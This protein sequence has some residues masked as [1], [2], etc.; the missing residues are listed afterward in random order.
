MT[1]ELLGVLAD[2]LIEQE[3][4]VD[5]KADMTKY[6]AI[7]Y[8]ASQNDFLYDHSEVGAVT[9][10][11]AHA[12]VPDLTAPASSCPSAACW[13]SPLTQAVLDPCGKHCKPVL[14]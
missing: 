3:L 5:D 9:C 7:T 1:Q 13:L 6:Q 11:L 12:V 4:L 8:S 10:A 14:V 2:P